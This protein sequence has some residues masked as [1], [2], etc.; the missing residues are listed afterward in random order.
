MPTNKKIGKEDP[1]D[2]FSNKVL[3][4]NPYRNKNLN[5]SIIK[6]EFEKYSEKF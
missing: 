6:T 4:I 1:V 5:V 2:D 3:P